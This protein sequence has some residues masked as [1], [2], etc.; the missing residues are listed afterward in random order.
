M[1][2]SNSSHPGVRE[3]LAL[4]QRQERE[5]TQRFYAEGIR[6][7]HQAVLTGA[8]IEKLVVAPEML[9]STAGRK[10]AG[11]LRDAGVSCLDV[12]PDLFRAL[13][14]ATEPQGI[15]IVVRQRWKRLASL[16]PAGELCWLAHDVVNSSGNLGTNLRTS[17]S[18]GG[19][20]VILLGEATDPYDPGTVRASM[21]AIFSQ[22]FVRAGV[23]EFVAWKRRHGAML[24]GTSP[25]AECDYRSV[26]YHKPLVLYIGCE[27]GGMA[28]EAQ[29]LCDVVVSL[30]MVG[31]S[32]SLNLAVATGVML[33][34]VFSQRHR[35]RRR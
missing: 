11:R 4:R 8:A 33:Y 23:E 2:I 26:A 25:H 7:V 24:V 19:A 32:D 18:V 15:G 28:A 29:A 3:V 13:S 22:R 21:G 6:F 10:I 20:G 30:P 31:R 1:P 14:L 9:R 35:M 17:D 27:Q 16:R 5:R 34:E 12:T